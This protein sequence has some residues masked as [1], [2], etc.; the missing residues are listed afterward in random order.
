MQPF[1][2]YSKRTESHTAG[3][4]RN[5][6]GDLQMVNWR[7]MG[8]IAAVVLLTACGDSTPA[9]TTATSNPAVQA[10][11]GSA[12]TATD[13]PELTAVDFFKALLVNNDIKEAKRHAAPSLKRVLD[14]Y[15]SAKAVGRT[16][17]NMSFDQVEITIEDTNKNVREFYTDKADVML[18]FTGKKNDEKV[19]NM[20]MVKM[21]KHNGKWLV[22][23][24]KDDPFARTKI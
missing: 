11:A 6:H 9:T 12:A 14:G 2:L 23:V 18:I 13:S 24:I 19:V 8:S 3:N 7:S 15:A 21:E 17:L 5:S 4:F 10:A 1:L 22:T 16:L 20:R